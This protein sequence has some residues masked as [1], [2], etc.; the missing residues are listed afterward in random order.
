MSELSCHQRATGACCGNTPDDSVDQDTQVETDPL[1]QLSTCCLAHGVSSKHL[2]GS[3]SKRL[4]TLV[5]EDNGTQVR[6]L[7]R[8]W[9]ASAVSF[10]ADSFSASYRSRDLR[11]LANFARTNALS[12]YNSEQ[13]N[14]LSFA[15]TSISAAGGPRLIHSDA[16]STPNTKQHTYAVPRGEHAKCNLQP[17][18]GS[19]LILRAILLLLQ[20]LGM[21]M[22]HNDTVQ[23]VS[24]TVRGVLW[25]ALWTASRLRVPAVHNPNPQS[26][27]IGSATAEIA[28][29]S[30][31]IS[32]PQA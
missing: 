11:A 12:Q 18:Q 5:R 10:S 22:C 6:S 13:Q 20:L 2:T 31:Q 26:G 3:G 17:V 16:A 24:K 29:S 14:A 9:V 23:A 8:C 19:A 1:H 32:C 15:L 27:R 30:E 21:A 7:A 25:F 28:T 4:N